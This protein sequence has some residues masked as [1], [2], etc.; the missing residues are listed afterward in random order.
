MN[1]IAL[2]RAFLC[3]DCSW[4]VDSPDSCHRCGN[5]LGLLSL[6]TVLNRATVPLPACDEAPVGKFYSVS[7]H[8]D[9]LRDADAPLAGG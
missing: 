3:P 6:G 4:I 7:S 1:A 9:S 2:E 8:A 5:C